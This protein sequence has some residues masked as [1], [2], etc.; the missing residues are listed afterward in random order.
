M[1]STDF[2]R[3]FDIKTKDNDTIIYGKHNNVRKFPI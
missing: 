1:F 3:D 2:D